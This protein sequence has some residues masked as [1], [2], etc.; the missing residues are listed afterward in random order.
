MGGVHGASSATIQPPKAV[1]LPAE[2][3]P[4]VW[5]LDPCERLRRA[6]PKHGIVEVAI[7]GSLP[8]SG[9]VLLL[10]G[11]VAYDEPVLGGLANCSDTLLIQGDATS[12]RPLAAQIRAKDAAV[13]QA[14]LEGC[15]PAPAGY[16]SAVPAEIGDAFRG[17]LRKR[18][19]PYC[20]ELRRDNRDE[21]ERRIYMGAYKGVTDLVTKYVW[22]VPAMW[23]TRACVRLGFT[24]NMVTFASFLLVLAALWLF[25]TG[26]FGWGLL[27]A[28][29]MT[30]L[31]TVDGKLARVTLTSSKFGNVFD[32]G[33]D[34][35]HPPFW[36]L[37]WAYGLAAA[38]RP[39]PAGWFVPA[40]IAIF[41]GYI[42]G[43]LCE[44]YFTRRFGIE[45]FV[46]TRF[47]SRFREITARRN[48]CLLLL[49]A[50][51]L[52]GRPELALL[53]VAGWIVASAA[54]HLLRALQAEVALRR[55]GHV[56]SWMRAV[57]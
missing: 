12:A 52:M 8:E 23:V 9:R 48:P 16:A 36:Y 35:V 57:T 41:A 53:A 5:G 45:L 19:A 40:V 37:A 7:G 55:C 21:A 32:H 34:L 26:A 18:E 42:L 50:G 31:D 22:P 14:W 30:F 54:V 56:N 27:A 24:P 20:L 15:G 46:W 13:A 44:G 3:A 28:W 10:R 33:I 47:D 2:G 49:T 38:G 39:L 51:W 1:V 4:R 17:K 43:R 11:D 6:L 29:L 25:W